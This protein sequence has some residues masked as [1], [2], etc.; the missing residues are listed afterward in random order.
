MKQML[1]DPIR[2]EEILYLILSIEMI[3]FQMQ[4]SKSDSV[5]MIIIYLYLYSFVGVRK[6]QVKIPLI[7]SY[8]KRA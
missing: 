3:L 7:K 5:M 6:L 8:F 4:S 2:K 1:R